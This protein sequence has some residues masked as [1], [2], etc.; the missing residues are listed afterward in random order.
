MSDSENATPASTTAHVPD[1]SATG[2]G[3][4]TTTTNRLTQVHATLPHLHALQLQACVAASYT[5]GSNQICFSIP[6]YGDV[7]IT[8]PVSI[9]AGGS[10]R[11]CA[12]TCGSIIPTGL[13]ATVYLNGNPIY[14]G[15]IF[16]SC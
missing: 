6:V 12:Q 4:S 11:A 9:P 1:Y 5:P 16:G 7:C 10:L 2:F 13:K 14:N 8:S 15:T 3:G